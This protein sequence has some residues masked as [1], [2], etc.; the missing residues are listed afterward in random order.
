MKTHGLKTFLLIAI[1]VFNNSLINAQNYLNAPQ[2]IAIDSKRDRLLVSN[3]NNGN[4]VEISN[5]GVQSIFIA[6]AECVDGIEIVGDTIF[7]IGSNRKIKAF[8][9]VTKALVFELTIAGTPTDYL[10]SIVSDSLGNLFFSCPNTNEIY[11]LRIRDQVYWTFAKDNSL[12]KPNG[13]LLEKEK[14]RIVVID[15]SSSPSF[16]HAISLIDSTVTTLTTT[17]FDRPDGI[18]RDKD[19]NYYV[20][21]YFL[22]GLYKFRSG[23]NNPPVLFYSGS[24]FVYP[25]YDP[26]NNTILVTY[27]GHNTWKRIPLNTSS[28]DE[29]ENKISLFQIQPNPVTNETTIKVNLIKTAAVQLDVYDITGKHIKNLVNTELKTGENIIKWDGVDAI[30]NG[31]YFVRL[32][33]DGNIQTQKAI[34]YK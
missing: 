16:I 21:G 17:S 12:N 22:P 23:L 4:L 30:N 25:T 11:R 26:S 10:S 13:I 28:I 9:L 34:L 20:G 33:I 8:N 7:A 31:I 14:N 27:Y 15:D 19:G 1:I 5:T 3:F 29:Q 18:V 32:N 2:K 6:G 24:H